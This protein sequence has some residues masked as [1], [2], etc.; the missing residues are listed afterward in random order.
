[1]DFPVFHLDFLGNR[2]LVALIAVLHVFIN[3]PFA[4]GAMPLVT[5]LEW[6][7]HRRGDVGWDRLAYR[8]LTVC[9]IVTTTVG[10]LTGVGIWFATSLV[11]PAAIGSL[12]RVFFWAWFAE[13]LVFV[14]E[15]LCIM[16]YYLTW[17][18]MAA[19][20]GLH[21]VVGAGL[22]V[23]SW[24]TMAIITA[25]LAFMMNP[26]SWLEREDFLSGVFNPIYLPQLAFRTPLAMVGAGLL[27]LFLTFF[28]TRSDAELRRR[29]VRW[30]SLWS[31]A[32]LSPTA[33][34][35]LWYWR[36]IPDW[37]A[38][39]VPVALGTQRFA[40]W[41]D[42][43]LTVLAAMV[44][45]VL[46]VA[47]AGAALPRRLPR[48]ALL[49]PF[50]L[51]LVLLG[52]FER[53]REFIRKPYVVGEYMYANGVRVADLPLL[54]E[55]GLL[56]HSAYARIREVTD[57]NQVAAGAE[58]FRLACTR[59]H[60]ASGVNS[61]FDRLH[62]LYGAGDWDRDTVKYYVLGMHTAR[63]FMPPF[64][65]TDVEAG[66]LADY[67]VACQRSHEPV[68]GAQDVGLDGPAPQP[69]E[70]AAAGGEV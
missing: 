55:E 63:P 14:T 54:K 28:F 16:V 38:A 3:H 64:P 56:R 42:Q 46:L 19:R 22:S 36:V 12:I 43:L 9:F 27:A 33:A 26:G 7:G 53:V 65:G 34:G 4:V 59:C 44:A 49:V 60:T 15:V 8:I 31:L 48:V 29:A 69:G 13:W 11:N 62:G 68:L 37:M 23:V 40:T 52:S 20:K 70:P 50:A 51:T 21:V 24:V 5:A 1:M 39:N 66:A 10:A 30:L 35:A 58:I 6:W 47:L 57:T 2:M 18:P 41:Y 67:L 61:V 17:K 45:V 25:I 32:W